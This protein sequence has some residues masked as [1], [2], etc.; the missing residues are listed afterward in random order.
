[1]EKRTLLAV[2][3]SIGVFYLFSYFYGPKQNANNIQDKQQAGVVTV[4]ETPDSVINSPKPPNIQE[5]LVLPV[6]AVPTTDIT[7]EN[8]LFVA[9]FSNS[10]AALK[11]LT[12]KS[13][14][15]EN[16]PES[17]HVTLL[18]SADP[19]VQ[20]YSSRGAG[21]SL[22]QNVNYSPSDTKIEISDKDKKSLTFTYV[23]PQGFVVKKIY[24]FTGDEYRIGL[25]TQLVNNAQIPIVGSFQNL[26]STSFH[27]PYETLGF[28]TYGSSVFSDTKLH[29]DAPKNVTSANKI[30]DKSIKWAALNEKYFISALLAVD[31]SIASV[32]IKKNQAGFLEAD[33]TTPQFTA[34]PGQ[35]V[36]F[37]HNIY[38]GPKEIDILKA[39]GSSF[40]QSLDLGWFSAIAKPM[41]YS[42][43]FFYKYVGNYGVAI[44]IIT[45]ILKIIFFP[46]THKSYKSMKEM[47]KLQPKMAALKE[48]Y[49][50]D[51]DSMNR[52]VMELY[53]EH[54]V[55][56][57]GGCLP[58]L[59]QIPVFFALYK[60]LMFS[61]ELRHAPFMLWITDLSVKDPYYVTPVIMGA[62]MFIQQKL[63]PSNMDEM[64]QKIMLFLPLIFIFMFLSF[65]AGLVL[66]WLVNNVLTIAQQIYINKLTKD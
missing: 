15:I 40:E 17:P 38:V 11:K 3:L 64:Q 57:L 61:I 30:Y 13:Y 33:F 41:L 19:E 42:L 50:N 20:N 45:I 22:P 29:T 51:R 1:M 63:T 12:L 37:K 2:V 60:A 58:M 55:N 10:G 66:Y 36:S 35:T 44:I 26:L 59:V 23:D 9:T 8:D 18:S 34:T 32:E 65:P 7:V 28:N 31:N 25:E 27:A 53:R 43:K 54:K 14:K 24:S 6:A 48:K 56:P 47:S 5:P 39:Q 46:L 4:T 21:F 16:E 49:K 62:T 52:A